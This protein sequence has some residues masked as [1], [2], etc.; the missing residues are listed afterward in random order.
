MMVTLYGLYDGIQVHFP[1]V[2]LHSPCGKQLFKHHSIVAEA[3]IKFITHTASQ[4]IRTI[5]GHAFRKRTFSRNAEIMFDVKGHNY[6]MGRNDIG[7]Q[8]LAA[9]ANTI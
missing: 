5:H 4:Y 9:L 3:T 1:V 8:G 2:E 6:Q 7:D